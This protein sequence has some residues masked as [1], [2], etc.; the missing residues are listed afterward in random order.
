MASMG[1][2][3]PRLNT[4]GNMHYVLQQ[5]LRGYARTDPPA[6]RV[7]PIPFTLLTYTVTNAI[8]EMDIATADLAIIGFFFLLRPGEHTYS[9]PTADSHPFRLCDVVFRL[10]ASTFSAA[11]G[12]PA[13]ISRATFVA[14]TFT[15]QKNGTEN[16]VV[17]HA[18]S[19]HTTTCPVLALIRRC[20]HLRSHDTAPTTPL[21]TVFLPSH[22]AT[23][24]TPSLLTAHLR[25]SATILFS[26]LGFAPLDVSARSL[27]AGGAMALLCAQVDSNVIK[28]IGRWR[29]DEMLRYLHLQSYPQMRNLAPLMA[30]GGQF[31]NNAPVPEPPL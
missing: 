5:Q 25:R 1:A 12:D 11:T 7:K 28:L 14:L 31:R 30:H 15:K 9:S 16:E 18:K 29:S 27:R 8:T 6:T 13:L 20:L 26:S 2:P 4:Q 17:G 23:F 19:G 21:C 22:P 3:D 24:I 10:G